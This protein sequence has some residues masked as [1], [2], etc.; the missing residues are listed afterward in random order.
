M[1]RYPPV[2]IN[3]TNKKFHWP[4]KPTRCPTSIQDRTSEAKQEYGARPLSLLTIS[5]HFPMPFPKSQNKSDNISD[6]CPTLVQSGT[7]PLSCSSPTPDAR[8]DSAISHLY[9]AQITDWP[10]VFKGTCNFTLISLCAQR[11]FR[12]QGEGS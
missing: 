10:L 5:T 4:L 11:C 6:V 7:I 12:K 2:K 1:E 9:L 3:K 8:L